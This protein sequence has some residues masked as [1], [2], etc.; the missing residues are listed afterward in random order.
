MLKVVGELHDNVAS[1]A[2]GVGFSAA[3]VYNGQ[4]GKRWIE[5]AVADSG[6]GM[7]R[8]V[9][10]LVPT[11][12][13]DDDAIKWC[14]IRGNTTAGERDSWAQRLPEDCLYSP[15][16]S[17]VTSFS[18]ENHH[19]GEGLAVLTELITIAAGELWIWSG[20]CEFTLDEQGRS[21]Y[22]TAD[23]I[24]WQGVAIEIKLDVDRALGA[25]A[26]PLADAKLEAL[27][28]RLGL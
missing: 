4:K 8:N 17:G 28:G 11:I 6:C 24:Q 9:R 22:R 5:F 27:A 13:S 2:S 26:T 25:L 1:H 18:N 12:A 19:L 3:Q 23:D 10:Q 14:L 15:L 7:L 21:Y 16:P 20:N